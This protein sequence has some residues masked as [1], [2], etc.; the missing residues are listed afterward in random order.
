M[1]L[2]Y[3]ANEILLNLFEYFKIEDVFRAFYQLNSRFNTLLLKYFR[4][5][6]LDFQ[7]IS[8][9]DFHLIC[10]KYFPLISNQI[11]SLRLCDEINAS[12]QLKY[13]PIYIPSFSQLSHLRA[14]SLYHIKSI[15]LLK[16]LVVEW[17]ELPY[18]THL[19]ITNC[20]FFGTSTLLHT[21]INS[22]WRLRRL[23]YCHLNRLSKEWIEFIVP[24]DT[25]S[26]MQYL[27]FQNG[28][29]NW[30]TST[31]LLEKT[32][33]LR[34]LNTH[35]SQI[36]KS[37][38]EFST[39]Y[40]SLSRLNVSTRSTA[41]ML[42]CWK[43]FPNLS[44]LTVC[45]EACYL[46]GKQWEYIIKTYLSC[47]KEFHLLMEFTKEEEYVDR[48]LDSFR[49]SFWLE[50]RQWYVRCHWWKISDP[51]DRTDIVL[52]TLPNLTGCSTYSIDKS[53]HRST[54]PDDSVYNS[55]DHINTLKY[56]SCFHLLPFVFPNI[57]YLAIRRPDHVEPWSAVPELENLRTLL[58]FTTEPY[59]RMRDEL[60]TILDRAS[61]LQTLR[62]L[63]HDDQYK[64]LDLKHP[65]IRCLDFGGHRMMSEECETLITNQLGQQ[66]E[67]L[68]TS[69]DQPEVVPPLINH[70][71]SLRILKIFSRYIE[72]PALFSS[73]DRLNDWLA[74][75]LPS[76]CNFQ[77][78]YKEKS[79]YTFIVWIR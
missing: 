33:F 13:I 46:D 15:H 25:S 75:H 8:K 53:C 74:S 17:Q 78:R 58:Y 39:E 71:R 14:L 54:C 30:Q 11:I 56:S 26:S 65:S 28:H 22:I 59:H 51:N 79:S 44:H 3:L 16:R 50:E 40:E 68:I 32:P 62:L 19:S 49:S 60:Q 57:S 35:I 43:S 34:S 70:L 42:S 45:M 7:S 20:Y 63:M 37:E 23:M 52:T 76:T 69:I 66:C 6:H 12:I 48:L 1:S 27:T 61:N 21:T 5:Y 36:S 4:A 24:D 47:L 41:N 29:M 18:L 72:T 64:F 2:E 73:E 10:T 38:V 67:V 55:Y 9:H 77:S 31:G